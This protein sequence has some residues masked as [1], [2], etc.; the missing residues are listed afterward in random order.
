MKSELM[1]RLAH[2]EYLE[3]GLLYHLEGP[4]KGKV[5]SHK[6]ATNRR[7]ITQICIEKEEVRYQLYR[8]VEDLKYNPFDTTRL[9]VLL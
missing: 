7:Q 5:S 4:N 9:S 2:L 1:I 6:K 3:F 8:L